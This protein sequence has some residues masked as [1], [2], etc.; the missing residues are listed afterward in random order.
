MATG[1]V[2]TETLLEMAYATGASNAIGSVLGVSYR[3]SP[4][5]IA[6]ALARHS[7]SP[8]DVQAAAWQLSSVEGYV[9]NAA[10]GLGRGTEEAVMHLPREAFELMTDVALS[11]W[12]KR[13]CSEYPALQMDPKLLAVE[14]ENRVRGADL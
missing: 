2:D 3:A 5:K 1:R 7:P 6:K 10:R 11:R 13:F 12:P 4:R 8:A 14:M 9:K